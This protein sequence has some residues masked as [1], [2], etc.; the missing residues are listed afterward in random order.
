MAA[1]TQPTTPARAYLEY[2]RD[3]G[4]HDFYRNQD[5]GNW[6]AATPP[7]PPLVPAPPLLPAQPP[8]PRSPQRLRPT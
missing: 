6:E 3:L 4:V 7:A 1:A 2:F 8:Q 5:P